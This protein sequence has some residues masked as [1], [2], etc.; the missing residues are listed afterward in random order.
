MSPHFFVKF[1]CSHISRTILKESLACGMISWISESVSVLCA[2]SSV[3]W[4]PIVI[5]QTERVTKM[6]NMIMVAADVA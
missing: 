2:T 6:I 4:W 1:S 5:D 3:I